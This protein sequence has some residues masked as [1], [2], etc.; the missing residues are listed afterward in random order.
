MVVNDRQWN[1]C[2]SISGSLDKFQL[3]AQTWLYIGCV[4]HVSKNV[5]PNSSGRPLGRWKDEVKD[6]MCER[7]ATRGERARSSKEGVF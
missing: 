6:C 7:G 2:S 4:V 3:P 5:G 1:E